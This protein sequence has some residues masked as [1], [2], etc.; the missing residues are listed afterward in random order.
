[1][2]GAEFWRHSRISLTVPHSSQPVTQFL[3]SSVS[4]ALITRSIGHG[5]E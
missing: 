1:L 5:H 2:K 3:S 4:L